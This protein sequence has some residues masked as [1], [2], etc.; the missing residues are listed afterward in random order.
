MRHY[1]ESPKIQ[2]HLYETGQIDKYGRVINLEKNK[3]KLHILEREFKQAE[4]SEEA[5]HKEEMDMRVSI[6]FY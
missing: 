3:T 4:K 5:K 2:K 6:I 1:F